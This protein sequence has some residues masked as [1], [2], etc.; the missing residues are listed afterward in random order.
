[1]TKELSNIYKVFPN[2]SDCVLYLENLLW[3][4]KP[5]CPYCDSNRSTPIKNKERFH[6]NKCNTTYSVTVGTIFHKTKVD[7][8]KWFFAIKLLSVEPN[9]SSRK[10]ADHL[11]V[12]KDTAWAITLKI[13]GLSNKDPSIIDNIIVSFNTG[14]KNG[15][16]TI[17]YNITK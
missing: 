14:P 2:Q 7:L 11:S 1:M 8:Q 3:N 4:N 10:L 5:V 17:N 12:T 13:K 9:I 6:C 16:K 15:S